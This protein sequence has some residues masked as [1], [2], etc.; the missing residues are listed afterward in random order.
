MKINILNSNFM[1]TNNFFTRAIICLAFVTS[2][3]SCSDDDIPEKIL[4]EEVITNVVLTFSNDADP[5][6]LVVLTN[7]AVDGQDGPSTNNVTGD[8]KAGSTYSL[9]LSILNK[10]EDVLTEDIIPEAD[11]HFFIYG[12]NDLDLTM[13]RDAD[14]VDGADGSKLGVKTTWVAGAAST[15]N[16]KIQLVHEPSTTDDSDNFGSTTGG[17]DDLNITFQNVAIK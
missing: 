8:F 7:I 11:E 1:K 5:T 12:V 16:I 2:I 10:D 13:T 3:V 14:D 6:D 17:S 15:G 9:T 4:E